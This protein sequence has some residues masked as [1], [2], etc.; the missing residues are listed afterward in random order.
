[1]PRR[2][3]MKPTQGTKRPNRASERTQARKPDRSPFRQIP[4]RPVT[5]DGACQHDFHETTV[6]PL[7]NP[8]LQAYCVHCGVPKP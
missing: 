4:T 2:R 1:M 6:G 7:K 3:V 8:I 5:V